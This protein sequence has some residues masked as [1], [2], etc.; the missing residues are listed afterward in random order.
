MKGTWWLAPAVATG[1]LC[2]FLLLPPIGS[3]TTVGMKIAGIF[4]FTVIL[5]V[6]VGISYPSLVCIGLFAALQ[7]MPPKEV[8]AASLGNWIVIFI[9]ACLGLAESLRATGVS[10]RFALW[11]MTRPFTTGRPWMMLTMFMLACLLLGTVMSSTATLVVCMAIAEPMLEVVGYKKGER[12]AAVVMMGLAWSATAAFMT[13]PIGHGS[14]LLLLE[15][16]E[17]DMGYTITFVQWIIIGIPIG[18]LIFL[19]VLGILRFIIRP[20]ASRFTAAATAYVLKERSKLG[21][22]KLEEKI[23]LGIFGVVVACWILPGVIGNILPEVSDYLN[24]IGYATPALI[25]CGLACTLQVKNKPLLSFREWMMNM[26]WSAIVLIAAITVIGNTLG[27][28]ESG[29][30]QFLTGIVEPIASGAPFSVFLFVSILWA[31]LQTN[32]MSNLVTATLVYTIMVPAAITAGV[33]NPVALGFSIFTA[34][35]SAFVLPSA[36]VVTAIV[37][38]SGWV[39]VKFMLRYGIITI[40]PIVLLITFVCYPFAAYIFR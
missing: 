4:L 31:G 27:S 17:R 37:T 21:S 30:P 34:T 5:W 26:E 40:I 18:L 19:M 1:I 25:G 16:A 32:I 38:G 15:W 7:V 13:T 29:I 35:R 14:N 20:D 22:M 9:I 28:S 3:V 39:P 23:A 8:F 36:T 24:K 6:F 2:T 33:G 10:R 11:F 12:F